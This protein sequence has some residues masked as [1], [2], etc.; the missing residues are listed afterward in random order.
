[1][2][3]FISGVLGLVTAFVMW[4][5]FHVVRILYLRIFLKSLGEETS[6]SRNVDLRSYRHI[7]I[8]CH[9]SVNKHVLLDGRGGSLVIG[10]N[11]DIAQDAQ[12]WT[13]QHDY[14]SPMYSAVGKPVRIDDYAWIGSR[15]IILPGVTVGQGA[16]VAAGAVVT[17]DVAPYTVV[18]GVPAKVIGLRS[19]ELHYKLGVRRW[20]T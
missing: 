16:V 6:I 11:V 5:P 7:S 4:V 18:G 15:S 10:N 20:F 17:H 12:I 1:M 13:L 8:G 2:R 14:N 19:K 9:T 3:D